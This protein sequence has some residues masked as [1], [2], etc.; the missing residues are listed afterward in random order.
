M[1]IHKM[2]SESNPTESID[3]IPECGFCSV[4]SFVLREPAHDGWP[5]YR[6]TLGEVL[7]KRERKAS[8]KS[9]ISN[10]LP[11]CLFMPTILVE[12]PSS[13]RV[14]RQAGDRSL[15]GLAQGFETAGCGFDWTGRR[16]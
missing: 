11:D 8:G 10:L 16:F 5:A 15:A 14:C 2:S 13:G 4:A 6:K 3:V 7:Y 9:E 12:Y 1:D